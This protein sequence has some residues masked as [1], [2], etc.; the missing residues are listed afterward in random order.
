[1]RFPFRLALRHLLDK[2]IRNGLTVAAISVAVFLLCFLIAIV[3]GLEASVRSASAT[4]LVTQSAVSLF[5][6]LPISY[7]HKIDSVDGVYLSTKFR[8]FGAY[9]QDQE[10]F[11]AQF[12]V[13]PNR[14]LDMYTKDIEIIEG[15]GGIT[16]PDAR[17]AVQKAFDSDRRAAII[18]TGLRDDERYGFRIGD[19]VPLIPLLYPR[20][21]GGAWD[22]VIVGYYRPLKDRIPDTTMY[23]RADYLNEAFESGEAYGDIAAGVY[24][25]NTL[26]NAPVE[27]VAQEIDEMFANG[28]QRTKTIT[29][30]AFASFFISA[31]GNL[32]LFLG[33]IG[34]AVLFSIFFSVVNTMMIS[35][36]QRI[37]E[38]GILQALGFRPITSTMLLI[39]E[40]LLISLIGGGC[41]IVLAVTTERPIMQMLGQSIRN[42]QITPDL[43]LLAVAISSI[44]GIV[45]GLA[46]GLPFLRYRPTEALRS[47]E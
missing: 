20:A 1:L 13:D 2:K 27:Q 38:A 19:T 25:V 45:A 30:A 10:N 7:Q 9:Y 47:F 16:G 34:G 46:A 28:P 24:Y 22:F 12:A 41:G 18:G 11:F 39:Y 31:M 36:R 43:V 3:Q 37:Q 14:F 6:S 17:A 40:G 15:P 29:E 44:L 42:Y 33:T 23:F 32:P 26:E 5:V 21:D 4:R 35:G 8:W